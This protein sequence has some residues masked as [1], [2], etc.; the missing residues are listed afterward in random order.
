V[1][2]LALRFAS[3]RKT[4]LSLL[5]LFLVLQA[6]WLPLGM[7][8]GH[9]LQWSAF[10][11]L[12]P[13]ALCAALAAMFALWPLRR[14]VAVLA[15]ALLTGLA[16]VA[17]LELLTRTI[18]ADAAPPVWDAGF[19]LYAVALALLAGG[20][21]R[22]LA[23]LDLTGAVGGQATA[24]LF[25]AWA[26]VFWQLL[27]QAFDVPRVLM[28]APSQIWHALLANYDTL[29]V[30][31]VQTVLHAVLIGY[32]I[33]C[34]LGFAVGVLI[35]RS[36]F[37]QRGLLPL[38][39]LASTVPL[40]GIA[41]IL[42]MWF[43]FDWPSKAAVVAVMTFFPMLVNTLAGLKSAGHMELDLMRSYG[44]GYW[45]TL[46][47]LRIPVALPFVFNALK[48][49]STLALIGAIVAEFFGSPISGL[50][51]R[52]STEA[53]RL[54]MPV[55]WAAILVAAVSGSL[56]FALLAWAE[57]RATFWH[58]SVRKT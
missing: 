57:R 20:S 52:I 37:L 41:P 38:S 29:A 1:S 25:G 50:G 56:L 53:A 9:A 3:P 23:A 28:P 35:D 49:N 7:L 24:V 55:V 6:L 18:S 17:P 26:L 14:T 16:A 42:V 36:P 39:A 46:V 5:P 30:D 22:R 21:I 48:I 58:P 45:R 19:W 4:L 10:P 27:I 51:F 12:L 8:D 44:A 31:F 2:A 43:G 13:F 32:A 40:I 15:F 54:N 33:G 11:T 47:S 34:G